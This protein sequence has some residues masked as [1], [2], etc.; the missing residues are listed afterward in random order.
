MLPKKHLLYGLIFSVLMFEI[1]RSI[2]LISAGIIFLSTFL[3]DIDHYIYFIFK[4]KKLNPIKAVRYFK[5]ARKKMSKMNHKKRREYYSGWCFLH[6]IEFLVILFL[7]G[8][9]VNRL[10]FLIFIG[11]TFHLFLDIIEETSHQG[12]IDKL[13]L[14]YDYFKFRKLKRI[15]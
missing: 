14:I 5:D 1:F 3:I 7:M 11:A 4:D 2:D 9:F 13:S 10:F 15:K 8:F 12:R 6:G